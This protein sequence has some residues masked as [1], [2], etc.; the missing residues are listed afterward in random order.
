MRLPSPLD[1]LVLPLVDIAEDHRHTVTANESN[2]P[3]LFPTQ[4]PGKHL[5]SGQLLARLRKIGP[6]SESGRCAALLDICTTMPAG[7]L[8]RLLGIS[9]AAADRWAAG[10]VRTAYAAE[11]AHRPDG[12]DRL[13]R[14]RV[15]S[16]ACLHA[17]VAHDIVFF[18]APDD[19]TAAATRLWGPSEAFQSVTCRFIEP[20]STNAEWDM[21][22]EAPAAEAPPLE[23]LLGWAWPEWVTAPL[24]D[25]A[26]VFAL[27]KR[28]TRAMAN[29]SP[30]ELEELRMTALL[31]HRE[32]GCPAGSRTAASWVLPTPPPPDST[33]VRI[34]VA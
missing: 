25:G 23:Q 8:E 16:A 30:A 24:N 26:E 3:W 2:T 1:T 10:A 12:R 5:T 29:A 15:C 34:T 7:V 31:V 14:T 21:Y 28:L 13:R 32:R 33:W 9:P 18:L 17:R 20:D 6:S 19:E 27:P 4:Q 22:F 11:V